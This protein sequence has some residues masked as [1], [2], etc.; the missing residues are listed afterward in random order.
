M[1]VERDVL[2]ARPSRPRRRNARAGAR[3]GTFGPDG[4]GESWRCR[5]HRRSA[6][7]GVPNN[8]EIGHKILLTDIYKRYNVTAFD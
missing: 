8:L 3:L 2:G 7:S 6:G 5:R 4:S 1:S